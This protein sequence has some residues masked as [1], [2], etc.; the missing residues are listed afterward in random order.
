MEAFDPNSGRESVFFDP[1]Q[2]ALEVVAEHSYDP[3]S[4][5][6]VVGVVVDLGHDEVVF[7][8]DR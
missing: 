1:Q 3:D 2:A 5:P 6:P 8:G 4:L 7:E